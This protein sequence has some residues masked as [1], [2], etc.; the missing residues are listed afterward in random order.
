MPSS[1][2]HSLVAVVCCLLHSRTPR[3][4]CLL[5]G[6]ARLPSWVFLGNQGNRRPAV[7]DIPAPFEH[8]LQL[9]KQDT[10]TGTC[11]QGHLPKGQ[12]KLQIIFEIPKVMK[13]INLIYDNG[14]CPLCRIFT[15]QWWQ[16]FVSEGVQWK[17]RSSLWNLSEVGGA[18]AVEMKLWR[19]P[20][21]LEEEVSVQFSMRFDHSWIFRN[22]G[23]GEIRSEETKV[24]V[25][26]CCIKKPWQGSVAWN[27]EY[28]L[29]HGFCGWEIWKQLRWGLGSGFLKWLAGAVVIQRLDWGWK[30]HVQEH[31]LPWPWAGGLSYLHGDL[32]VGC[33]GVFTT[34]QL[35]SPRELQER[36]SSK[37]AA[38]PSV[39]QSLK[40]PL[41]SLLELWCHNKVP[42]T[43]CT[44]L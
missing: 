15:S 21:V 42:Q 30:V 36:T 19:I 8:P 5:A 40:S 2:C 39:M 34:R 6:K 11:T 12:E 26:C 9:T 38:M 18:Q 20:I 7:F 4:L 44:K 17:S 23:G 13:L 22:F 25:V 16:S 3:P 32:S 37:E 33:S 27:N 35:N 24:F 10:S 29:S 28:L 31:S 1:L 14:N 41:C 43:G